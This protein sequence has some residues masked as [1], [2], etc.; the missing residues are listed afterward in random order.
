MTSATPVTAGCRMI[1]SAHELTL[2][3]LA[4]A[5]T[6][7]VYEAV[8]QSLHEGMTQ[9]DVADLIAAAYG[10][11]GFSRRCQRTSRR[12]LGSS[13]TDRATPQ[14]IREGTIVMIDDGCDVEGYESDITR[15]FV[16]GKLRNSSR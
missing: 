8:Y 5:V 11:A 14:V 6:L 7:A 10:Q 15:T 9:H 1:K 16:L 13:L 12:I 4:N 2:M 3:G